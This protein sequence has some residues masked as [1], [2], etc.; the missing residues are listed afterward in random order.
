[1][2]AGGFGSLRVIDLYDQSVDGKPEQPAKH[3][4]VRANSFG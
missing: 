3:N 2:D 1:V 4:R